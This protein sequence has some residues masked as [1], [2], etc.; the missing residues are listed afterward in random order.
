M[1]IRMAMRWI[2][3]WSDAALSYDAWMRYLAIDLGGKRTGLAMGSDVVG[4]VTPLRVIETTEEARLLA[5]LDQVMDEQQ[6]DALVL[7]LPLNMDDTEGPAA[8]KVR[9]FADR[10]VERYQLNIHFVDERLSSFEVDESQ[11]GMTRADKRRGAGQDA[12][13]AKVILER[14]FQA[15]S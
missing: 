3:H 1:P 5:A 8:K 13:A 12:L 9:A 4:L 6:P 2:G 10:L 14:F 15:Q 7:G 11:R